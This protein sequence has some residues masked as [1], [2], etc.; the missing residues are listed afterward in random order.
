MSPRRKIILPTSNEINQILNKPKRTNPT[1]QRLAN[2]YPNSQKRCKSK[3]R[4][5]SVKEHELNSR[6]RI[7]NR[8]LLKP[9]RP[10]NRNQKRQRSQIKDHCTEEYEGQKLGYSARSV[11]L[12]QILLYPSTLQSLASSTPLIKA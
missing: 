12:Q 3:P 2:Q 4:K 7:A 5:N 6:E 8:V 9:P 1:A 11:I 10:K